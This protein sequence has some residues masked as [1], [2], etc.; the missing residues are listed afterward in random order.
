MILYNVSFTMANELYEA[1]ADVYDEI[2]DKILGRLDKRRWPSSTPV[3]VEGQ[4]AEKVAEDYLKEIGIPLSPI[5]LSTTQ[6]RRRVTDAGGV[7]RV[8]GEVRRPRS[9]AAGAQV[10]LGD[11]A[12]PVEA[13]RHDGDQAGADDQHRVLVELQARS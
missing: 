8:S 10:A 9:E 7:R 11:G 3:D 1:N 4:P 5:S 6:R 12:E 2:A 13:Q